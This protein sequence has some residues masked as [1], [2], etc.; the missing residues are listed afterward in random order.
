MAMLNNQRVQVSKNSMVEARFLTAHP[1]LPLAA[2]KILSFWSWNISRNPQLFIILKSTNIKLI[3]K[4]HK[5]Q[6]LIMLN[7]QVFNSSNIK[8]PWKSMEILHVFH[9]NTRPMLLRGAKACGLSSAER[10]YVLWPR[11]TKGMA[12]T[13]AMKN[14]TYGAY[15]YHCSRSIRVLLLFKY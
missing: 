2:K 9:E 8:I 12:K 11:R 3:I 1:Q 7:S 5:Y 13:I 14:P 4:Y 6:L 15:K 10:R